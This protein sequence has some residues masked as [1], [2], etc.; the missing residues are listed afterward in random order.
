M[1]RKILVAMSGGVDSS[2]AAALMLDEG[3]SCIG[4]TMTISCGLE[5]DAADARAVCDALGI[6]HS[7]F[8]LSCEFEREVIRHFVDCYERGL[9]PNPCVVCNRRIKFGALL[10]R[11]MSIGCDLVATGH[12]ARIVHENGR[13][14]IKKG[15]DVTKDQSYVLWSLTQEQLSR[16]ILPLGSLSKSEVRDIARARGFESADKADSQDI[17]FVPDGDYAAFIERFT[18]KT[19]PEGDFVDMRGNVLGRHRGMI[20]YTVGQ[21]KGLGLALPA[22]MYVYKKDMQ[23]NRVVLSDNGSLFSDTL[24]TDN[25]NWVAFERPHTPFTATVKTRYKAKEAKATVTPLENG[26]VK[27]VFDEPQRAITPGQ[28]AVVYI[29]DTLVGGGDIV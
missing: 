4:G 14:L 12:Y 10:E 25:F 18:G 11:G 3:R 6:E 15:H 21:R 17:C 26:G 28:A 23:N 20:R 8:D 16:V 27:I 19:Y 2:V 9:T 1:D 5:N 24:I 7:I 13:Y 29:D 22:P